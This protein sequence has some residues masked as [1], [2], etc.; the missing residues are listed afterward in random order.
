MAI[1]SQIRQPLAT[2]EAL[3]Q[4]WQVAGLLKPS[5]FKP[6]IATIEQRSIVKKM[7][8]LSQNDKNSLNQVIQTIL[9]HE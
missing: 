2:G 8:Q 4:D 9:G 1:T 5:V 3:L 7:G 6:L